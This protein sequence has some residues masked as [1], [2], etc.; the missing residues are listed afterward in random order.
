ML[1]GQ[2]EHWECTF[3]NDTENDRE[4]SSEN[5]T[6]LVRWD[7]RELRADAFITF[8]LQTTSTDKSCQS[9]AATKMSKGSSQTVKHA[10]MRA[11]RPD[12]DFSFDFQNL[13]FTPLIET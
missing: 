1:T 12:T 10:K 9:P 5:D 6:F 11:V 3:N 8:T 2:L 13:L 4:G 7:N